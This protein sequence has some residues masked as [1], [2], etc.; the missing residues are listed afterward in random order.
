MEP[1]E[2]PLSRR[3]VARMFR[4]SERQILRWARTGL[5]DTKRRHGNRYYLPSQVRRVLDR[6]P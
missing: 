6:D 3:E 4:V 5:I 1:A 2:R